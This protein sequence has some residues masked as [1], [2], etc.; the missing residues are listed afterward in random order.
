MASR[1]LL[2]SMHQRTTLIL[3]LMA[4][5]ARGPL[6]AQEERERHDHGAV[7][8]DWVPESVD[9]EASAS[10]EARLY[11]NRGIEAVHNFWYE[12]AREA[13]REAQRRQADFVLAAWGEA[14]SYHYPFGFSGGDL[15]EM[16]AA[17][18]R[19][20]P[21][22]EARAALAP[23]DRERRYLAAIEVLAG[24]GP[25]EERRRG[26]A[27]KMRELAEAYPDDEEAWAFYAIS[28]FGTEQNIRGVPAA[29]AEA[30]RAA[31]RVLEISPR[32]PGG[33]HYAIHALD[34]P[35]TAH[36]VVDAART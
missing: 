22:P 35:Q 15:E 18:D 25:E 1:R 28:V 33:L 24:E 16:R 30:A 32:H 3:L 14:F 26:F 31:R 11:L 23:T 6:V 29:R 36:R 10:Q 9:M 7:P 20:A 34:T 27:L 17:L 2:A 5:A 19:L 13:F 12:A 21:T 4:T 8:P